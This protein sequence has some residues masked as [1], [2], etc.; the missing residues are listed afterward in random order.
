MTADLLFISGNGNHTTK[1][2]VCNKGTHMLSKST[3]DKKI[4][5]LFFT[6]SAS[7]DVDL[8]HKTH[9]QQE[10]TLRSLT[11]YLHRFFQP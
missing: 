11:K 9:S 6:W 5:V 10:V 8:Y 7:Q 1:N 3:L 4:Q 2:E